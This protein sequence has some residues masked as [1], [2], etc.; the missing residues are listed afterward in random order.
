MDIARAYRFRSISGE[1]LI[2]DNTTLDICRDLGFKPHAVPQ[3][4]LIRVHQML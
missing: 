1:I 3:D 4:D 2:A